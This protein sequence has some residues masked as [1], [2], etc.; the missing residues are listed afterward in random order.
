VVVPQ[1]LVRFLVLGV[2]LDDALEDLLGRLV[3][4]GGLVRLGELEQLRHV[5]AGIGDLLTDLVGFLR[6]EGD[7]RARRSDRCGEWEGEED[8]GDDH[9][10]FSG[11]GKIAGERGGAKG[12]EYARRPAT[13]SPARTSRAPTPGPL[14]KKRGRVAQHPAC[15]G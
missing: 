3:V 4:L 15:L 8:G 11:F 12:G 1:G 10:S 2:E 9:G 5:R 7:G 6:D 13:F 14:S